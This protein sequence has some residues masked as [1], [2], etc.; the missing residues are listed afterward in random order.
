MA[1]I[2]KTVVFAS[3]F[4]GIVFI[5]LPSRILAWT[6]VASPATLGW[7]QYAAMVLGAAGVVLGLWCVGFFA[8][9][10]KGT[11]APFDPPRN[12]V[13]RG[14]YRFVRNPMYIGAYLVLA[15]TAL[16]YHSLGVAIFLCLVVAWSVLMVLFKEEPAL[17]KTFGA[18]YEDYCLH[19]G[20][21]LPG[22]GARLKE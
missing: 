2:L 18:E 3:F 7:P 21:W 1:P 17:R 15:G 20:R 22:S 11:P 6:G 8:V 9:I 16:Y 19:V 14:P 5:F 4:I 10:G 13:I 12:L